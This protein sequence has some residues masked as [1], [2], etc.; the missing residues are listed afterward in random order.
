LEEQV[1]KYVAELQ[2]EMTELI[3]TNPQT[4]EEK[5]QVF[6]LKKRIVDR[7]LRKQN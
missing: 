7:F 5:H 2:A 1:K 6:M 4:S 3:H